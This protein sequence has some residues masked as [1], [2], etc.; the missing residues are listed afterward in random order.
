VKPAAAG[1]VHWAIGGEIRLRWLIDAVRA[2]YRWISLPAL[3]GLAF[4][5]V[6]IQIAICLS[7]SPDVCA[8]DCPGLPTTNQAA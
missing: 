6:R 8:C 1:I 3:I 5:M 4:R 7:L 2:V